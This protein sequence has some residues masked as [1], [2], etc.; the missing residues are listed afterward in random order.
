V[1]APWAWLEASALLRVVGAQDY[2][3]PLTRAWGR[4]GPYA[5]LDARVEVRPR[6]F[7]AVWVRGT[8]LLD[9]SY[10]TEIGFPDP[11]RVLWVGLKLT[12]E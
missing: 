5:V 7:V 10:Q 3:D 9:T 12:E 6:P 1:L 11:G 4:L 2:Q 8:N